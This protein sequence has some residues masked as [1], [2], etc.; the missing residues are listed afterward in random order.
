MYN[1]IERDVWRGHERSHIEDKI[2]KEKKKKFGTYLVLLLIV[3]SPSSH[4]RR[5]RGTLLLFV[6][7]KSYPLALNIIRKDEVVIRSKVG[8]PQGRKIL[9]HFEGGMVNFKL[10]C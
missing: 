3:E 9:P 10:F 8:N 1:C 6:Y 4:H 2:E 7:T 5:G